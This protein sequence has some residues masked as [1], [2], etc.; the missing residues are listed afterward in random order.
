MARWR[1]SGF[2]LLQKMKAIKVMLDLKMPSKTLNSVLTL[3]QFKR[4]C[5]SETERRTR[6]R[7][8]VTLAW[9]Q[10]AEEDDED[11]DDGGGGG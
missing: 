11:D 5:Q 1:S 9:K 7:T 2:N 3:C 8:G 6:F 4:T 10:G